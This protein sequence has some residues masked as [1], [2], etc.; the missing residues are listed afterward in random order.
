MGTDARAELA[1]RLRDMRAAAGLN[2]RELAQL[3]ELSIATLSKAQG[4]NEVPTYTVFSRFVEACG[5]SPRKLRRLFDQAKAAENAHPETSTAIR[6]ILV[7]SVKE[8]TERWRTLTA[9]DIRGAAPAP[10]SKNAT[11][12]EFVDRLGMVK[13]W[14]GMSFE[15]IG[16]VTGWGPSTLCDAI[17]SGRSTLP[18]QEIVAAL[19][20]SC[21]ITD[22]QVRQWM[23]AWFEIQWRTWTEEKNKKTAP[24]VPQPA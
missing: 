24:K 13:V 11:V 18:R 20:V 17:R 1:R 9:E 6:P 4:G 12:A 16:R 15:H 10:A 7:P 3:T 22:E 21:G 8:L 23:A 19:L 2:L 5:R 14:S